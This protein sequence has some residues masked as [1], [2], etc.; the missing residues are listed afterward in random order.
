[1]AQSRQFVFGFDPTYALE[2]QTRFF[3]MD[4]DRPREQRRQ[5]SEQ[6][7]VVRLRGRHQNPRRITTGWVYAFRALGGD[8]PALFARYRLHPHGIEPRVLGT[9]GGSAGSIQSTLSL[10]IDDASTGSLYYYWFV[11]VPVELH[12]RTIDSLQNGV[13]A[14]RVQLR[15]ARTAERRP[16]S[17]KR[18]GREAA[19][20][21]TFDGQAIE[22]RNGLTRG[23]VERDSAFRQVSS[24]RQSLLLIVEP[25]GISQA[26][27]FLYSDAI[28][29]LAT[30][31]SDPR[32]AA[33]LWVGN[34]LKALA[35]G[36]DS[37]G[38]RGCLAAGDLSEV[39][40]YTQAYQPEVTRLTAARE[41]AAL[42]VLEWYASGVHRLLRAAYEDWQTPEMEREMVDVA[43]SL[44]DRLSE[45]T[46]GAEWLRQ[47]L[48]ASS[49]AEE[50]TPL[51]KHVYSE[52][53]LEGTQGARQAIG[54]IASCAVPAAD[55]AGALVDL[56]KEIVMPTH[57]AFGRASGS[58]RLR[59]LF[60]LINEASG[61]R[62]RMGR[63]EDGTIGRIVPARPAGSRLRTAIT[64]VSGL[65]ALV[66]AVF[67]SASFID[68]SQGELQ[69]WQSGFAATADALNA[70]EAAFDI[71]RG[72]AGRGFGVLS[73]I[74]LSRLSSAGALF[75]LVS[76]VYGFREARR[77]GDGSVAFGH[78]VAAAGSGMSFVGTWVS[79]SAPALGTGIGVAA[80]G[81]G[82]A[83]WLI[84]TL[85]QDS[86][87][88]T[89]ASFCSWGE[90]RAS[91]GTG[92]ASPVWAMGPL[93][94]LSGDP[95]RQR[96]A[97]LNVIYAFRLTA[98]SASAVHDRT[99]SGTRMDSWDTEELRGVSAVRIECGL[100]DRSTTF[101]LEFETVRYA[102]FRVERPVE[103]VAA[104]VLV[105]PGRQEDGSP[106]TSS[107]YTATP[108]FAQIVGAD[109]SQFTVPGVHRVPN[110]RSGINGITV[111][112]VLPRRSTMRS[113][114]G[115]T[116]RV[117]RLVGSEGGSQRRVPS[118]D[119]WVA[120]QL[121]PSGGTVSSI[122]GE[123]PAPTTTLGDVSR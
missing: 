10:D 33:N 16:D 94:D 45:S 78:L 23:G 18:S 40:E 66:D 108:S 14:A 9:S 84:Y 101:E 58:G 20:P 59:E 99:L 95:V 46:I 83:G 96:G 118:S 31:V 22:L 67:E 11:S 79:L 13:F 122:E 65:I 70:S 92:S 64:A 51:V 69:R 72:V 68:D 43:A 75:S 71:Y 36:G 8:A 109:A 90:D 63:P 98:T 7:V 24:E 28:D 12:P 5:S 97:L 41:N 39:E 50:A 37:L 48:R 32:R 87:I 85:S 86:P 104:R 120:L 111:L 17:Q 52:Y 44:A 112:P 82:V 93:R 106:H 116:V 35:A 102:G 77:F 74:Q 2:R 107:T 21:F 4:M 62:P 15:G 76:D 38:L 103:S 61:T 57:L 113:W 121:A 53:L 91:R 60:N 19:R 42:Q 29:A 115:V 123:L 3:P 110:T 114:S 26:R 49:P 1:M 89:F 100:I 119:E 30:Y 81:V 55:V 105:M 56:F 54:R 73:D 117:R 25:L 6:E 80:V 88:Q 34:T 47:I 27:R